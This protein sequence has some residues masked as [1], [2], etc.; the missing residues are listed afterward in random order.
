MKVI[1]EIKEVVASNTVK[2]VA[3]NY[4]Q[5]VVE[6][7]KLEPLDAINR[8]RSLMD[9]PGT[10]RDGI[11]FECFENYILRLNEYDF[12]KKQFE[13]NN[14]KKLMELLAT[15]SP[16]E[17]AGYLGNSD[18]LREYSKRIVKLIDDCG[19]IEKA[20]YLANVSRA[21]VKESIDRNTFFKLGQCI[22][23][24][25]DEDLIFLKENVKMGVISDGAYIDDFRGQ[26]LMY[27]VDGGFAYTK[28]AF[29]LLKYGLAYESN[30]KI[31]E[32][33]LDRNVISFATNDDISEMFECCDKL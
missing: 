13:R 9:L 29:E 26:G 11:F 2:N 16:N 4:Y 19:T 33:F 27:D 7:F 22:R 15:V 3:K 24:L 10:I 6:T 30:A 1:K 25:T 12:E 8:I 18:Q 23:L 28:R 31:P 21:F 5:S 17:E 14:L 32:T 20:V